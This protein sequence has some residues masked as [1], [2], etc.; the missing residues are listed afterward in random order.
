MIPFTIT[1]DIRSTII[2]YLTTTFNFQEKEVERAFVDFIEQKEGGLF[3]GPYINLRLPF[4]KAHDN[5]EIPLEISPSFR[6]YVH[7]MQAF[8]RL[9]VRG[10]HPPEA[11]IVTTGT[12]SGK[13]ECFLYPVLDYCH[14]HR[15]EAGI[16]AIILYPMNALAS[17][18][19]ARLAKTIW[20][21]ERLKGQV[22]AGIYIG[23]G[24]R[25][26]DLGAKA[27][28]ETN[29]IENHE[30]LRNNPPDI[31]LTNYK[32]LD[33]LLLR[34]EDRR[35][36]EDNNPETLRF[37]VL[38][39]LHTYDG[40]QGSDVACLIRRLKARLKSPE[41]Y[42]CPVGTSA[43]VAS[44]QGD[45]ANLLTDF[46]SEIFGSTV[47][48]DA[49]IGENRLTISEFLTEAAENLNIPQNIAALE[50]I[51]GENLT[52]YVQRQMQSWFGQ[53][54]DPYELAQALGKHV[55]LRSLLN[56]CENQV[57]SVDQL[58]Q[59]LQTWDEDFAEKLPQDQILILQSFF[60]LISYAKVLEGE[61]TRPYL[62]AQVQLWVREMRRLMR[63]VSATPKYFWRDDIPLNSEQRGLPPYFCR[64]CGHSGWLAF[65]R[66]GDEHLSD[67][68][69]DIYR[70]YF[71]R[72][73]N[74]RYVYQGQRS[75]ELEGLS[76]RVCPL[77]LSVTHD[78]YCVACEEK[79]LSAVVTVELTEPQGKRM[80]RDLQ[81]CPNCGTD[82]ALS[83]VGSQSAS[84]SSVAIS[85][86]FTHPFN[87]D[88]KLLAF[89]DSVQDA[90]HRAGFFGARTYRFSLRTA[91]QAI[92]KDEPDIALQDFTQKMIDYWRTQWGD[93]QRLVA[94]FM[95]PDLREWAAYKR[96][97]ISDPGPLPTDLSANFFA[98]LSW[99]VF[100][101][102]GFN[103][104]L[105][106]SLEKVGSSVAYIV[107]GQVQET[108]GNIQEV[109]TEEFGLLKSLSKDQV[110]HF[111]MGLLDRTRTRG[112]I[113]HHLLRKYIRAEGNWYY[114]TKKER[115]L[116]SPFHKRSP[117]FPKFLS[118]DP[119]AKVFDSFVST[120]ARD[121]WYVDWARKTLD[122]NLGTTDIN[123]IYRRAANLLANAKI[124][125]AFPA[126][127]K[128][129][130]GINPSIIKITKNTTG[131]ICAECGHQHTISDGQLKHW[132]NASCLA[133]RCRGKYQVHGDFSDTYYRG[134][135]E[136]GNVE[137]IFAQE[138]TGLL[139][140]K[141]REAIET[142]FKTK[143][144]ADAANLLTATPTLEMGIDIGDLSATMAC[145]VPPA[146][147]NYLQR[148]GRAGRQTGNS[149]ILTFANAQPH[150]LYF[151]DDP[152]EMIAGAIVPPGTFLNAPNMLFRHFFAYC[153][154]T[155]V[156]Q[157]SELKS[158]P[159]NVRLLFSSI[160][161]DRFPVPFYSYY[162][163]NKSELTNTFIEIFDEVISDETKEK[164]S[165]FGLGDGLPESIKQ[166]I[167]ETAQEIEELRAS[168]AKL[169]RERK[170]IEDDPNQF[171][172]PDQE[173]NKVNQE[174]RI[175][176][177]MVKEIEEQYILNFFTDQG[178]L[179][180]Y[181]FP[182][183]GVK[184]KAVIRGIDKLKKGDKGY[185]IKEYIR[186]AALAIR[187]FAPDNMFYAE[188]RKLPITHLDLSGG[189]D[190]V[191]K[192]QFCD[193]CSHMELVQTSHYQSSCPNCGSEMWSDSGQQKNMIYFRH[194]TSNTDNN[195]SLVQDESEDRTRESYLTSYFFEISPEQSTGAYLIPSLPFGVEHLSQVTLR[196]VNFGNTKVGG[197]KI[198]IADE[199][200][201]ESGFQVCKGCGYVESLKDEP[202]EASTHKRNCPFRSKEPEW[203]HLY[204]YREVTSE[205]MRILLPVSTMLF[206]EKLATF[207]A[208]LD[209]GLR[210]KFRGNPD[211]IKI[212]QHQ[213]P[214]S[215]NT[216]KRYLVL[217]D[218]VPGGTSFLRDLFNPDEFFD[219]LKLALD[220]ISSCQCRLDINK[221]ACYRCLYT[222]RVQ[223]KLDKISRVL[224][225]ELLSAILKEKDSHEA[226]PSLADVE[227]DTL[228]ESE[229]E[230]RFIDAII[231]S[232]LI[233]SNTEKLANGKRV[234]EIVVS[235]SHWLI[236]PQVDLGASKGVKTPTRADFI[237]W[238][239]GDLRNVVLPIA[240]YTDG[241]KY[242]VMPGEETSRISD[243]VQK[244]M[245]IIDSGN[246][247]VWSIAWDDVIEFSEN[248]IQHDL[249]TLSSEQ[250]TFLVKALSRS[251][252]PIS[253][254][255][256]SSNAMSQLFSYLQHPSLTDWK[257]F[258]FACSLATMYPNRPSLDDKSIERIISRIS[259]DEQR[260]PLEIEGEAGDVMYGI[261]EKDKLFVF[262]SG[263]RKD[264]A[265]E[266]LSVIVRLS[267][268][269]FSRI[270][271]DFKISWRRFLGLSNIFQFL[272]KFN[273]ITD[274]MIQQSTPV[275]PEVT[276]PLELPDIW[277]EIFE[278][279][280]DDCKQI[281]ITCIQSDIEAPEVGYELI[282][283]NGNIL[284]MAELAWE[285]KKIAVFT[286]E[287]II[288][289]EIFNDHGWETYTP[290]DISE[291]IHSLQER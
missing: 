169:R 174:A 226:V 74:I 215:D 168:H 221:Q 219:L 291:T 251:K 142:Q 154:D 42:I 127:K 286:S 283:S 150:D 70:A 155:W 170:K 120:G 245:G 40:A 32:M 63:E 114:L 199:E 12:G 24:Q 189:D 227:I 2:D 80:P 246:Y 259:R 67:N 7:Q 270:A 118:D 102:Y 196:E 119:R 59:S 165:D 204:L 248:K 141:T 34:P 43:T 135:Y 265:G 261:L 244:R 276:V 47:T 230:Q 49:V 185:L 4:R 140:R 187:E 10:D 15:R 243:D 281:L 280:A 158:L 181:A 1:E 287:L 28:G 33:F 242:H 11:T 133:Y 124:L 255:A 111:I 188:G 128:T 62:T 200:R 288:E 94:T 282:D 205:A 85:N 217:Y 122:N 182:E 229:L 44:D 235:G 153:L 57:L 212:L 13:T 78:E 30:T 178:L 55:F 279:A 256:F 186:P 25:S 179:P 202:P 238:P 84:L 126:G 53:I 130:Y 60:A 237:I 45:S 264:I 266:R 93:D 228:I 176:L 193:S 252:T 106:R 5:Q 48:A 210:L 29:L 159:R 203:E 76:E 134:F 233:S 22:S 95:P 162:E 3:K 97:M 284:G 113:D 143:N 89:T 132:E 208:C 100:M 163:E 172:D 38:D 198:V 232:D 136:G 290:G 249:S 121:T 88:K 262:S 253:H 277:T 190:P 8:E 41:G 103:A 46:A 137:R 197:Q 73:K 180:N 220:H 285:A 241:Y 56:I 21:D 211:H 236:E 23:G 157:Q 289:R 152:L 138:H 79:T 250:L 213:E 19:A 69:T 222:H 81:R 231:H 129:S 167:H 52:Q 108:I 239:K 27:M 107:L 99:E 207:E 254:L 184:L 149:L 51:P 147:A 16:K 18:Q 125:T 206:E 175:I 192:W 145:S 173:L 77:C 234:W 214:E 269:Y 75:D 263:K 218:T 35:L 58:L 109:L 177:E 31:L 37:L 201:P 146:P 115:P 156:V 61:M 101:E 223:R 191:Q 68:Y 240:V 148:I 273:V 66:D 117:R 26:A 65:M 271:D 90:S 71:E 54:Y 36:W 268:N 224:G 160:K 194:A 278:Y 105:G 6:P 72:H 92:L 151:F 82:D 96:F 83:I 272:E 216:K 225:I 64:E 39:E 131:L 20:Q 183:T 171:Q 112:G 161:N 247:L 257:K 144:R 258:A 195:Q 164:L 87:Q 139:K 104:R 98:R 50:E 275:E 91:L 267:D 86:L 123:D 209:L 14:T 17:D 9:S 166:A 110:Q 274:E 116:L 260:R